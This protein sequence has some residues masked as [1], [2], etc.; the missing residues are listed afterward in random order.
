VLCVLKALDKCIYS[1]DRKTS[2]SRFLKD[3]GRRVF[4][5]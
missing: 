1:Y 2:F 3:L 5:V 4:N